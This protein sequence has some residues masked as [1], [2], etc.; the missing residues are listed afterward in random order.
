MYKTNVI[1]FGGDR[2]LEEG[3]LSYIC[4]FLKK[5]GIDFII[6][7]DPEHLKKKIN[8]KKNFKKILNEKQFKFFSSKK[9]NIKIIKKFIKPSTLGLSINSIWKFNKK[10]INLFNGKLFNYHAADLPSERGGANISWRILLNKNKNISINIHKVDEE[11][12]TGNIVKRSSVNITKKDILPLHQL[13]KIRKKEKKFLKEFIMDYIKGSKLMKKN[14]KNENSFYWP[15]LKSDRDGLINWEWTAKEIVDFILAFS[16]PFNGAFAYINKT[17]VRIFYAKV[18]KSKVKFHPF[19]NG[20]IFKINK[21]SFFV[22]NRSHIIK[23]NIAH[24]FGLKKRKSFYL[25]KR[26]TNFRK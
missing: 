25:G 21:N 6:F 16:K 15:R 13:N 14:Q 22:S 18:L 11:F 1:V 12:D 17:K 19:Q 20:I 7:T 10:T 23:I 8:D 3:P 2:L 4:S 26:L 5:K 9:L 24:I